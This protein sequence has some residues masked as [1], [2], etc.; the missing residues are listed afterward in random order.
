MKSIVIA[1]LF[2]VAV[3]IASQLDDQ[4]TCQN[5]IS[6]AMAEFDNDFI[7][8]NNNGY[9]FT[10]CYNLFLNSLNTY[11]WPD[12]GVDFPEY[13]GPIPLANTSQAANAFASVYAYAGNGGEQHI[14]GLM[15][16][17]VLKH[18][19]AP[20]SYVF[21]CSDFD[22]AR[23]YLTNQTFHF[24]GRKAFSCE[25]RNSCGQPQWKLSYFNWTITDSKTFNGTEPWVPH[26]L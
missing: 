20:D 26:R 12:L 25:R 4:N 24:W 11:C 2:T 9:N 13:A 23:N 8:C 6:T 17:Q 15:N 1:L 7:I 3:G 19:T 16:I 21:T 10:Q 5:L 14:L 18:D 22:I